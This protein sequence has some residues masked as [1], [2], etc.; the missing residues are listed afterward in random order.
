MGKAWLVGGSVI[1]AALLTAAIVVALLE[2]E[3]PLDEG[4]PE[5]AVQSFLKAMQN[6]GPASA[7][8]FF[9]AELRRDCSIEQFFGRGASPKDLLKNA[10][11]TLEETATVDSAT[12][13]TVRIAQFYGNGPFGTSESSFR[14]RFTLR[15]EE[16]KWKFTE[17][18]WPFYDCGPFRP[19]LEP[20]QKPALEPIQEPT[21]GPTRLRPET[22]PA[23]TPTA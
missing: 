16:G 21:L 20:R 8:D 9:S 22:A 12:F 14:H 19:E 7:Y 23:A 6:D 2:R 4:T 17:Y 11:I 10:R 5:A 1:L 18:P 3:E 15:Q 13:V